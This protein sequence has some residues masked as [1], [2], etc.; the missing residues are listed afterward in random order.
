[1]KFYYCDEFVL[2]LPDRH[3]FPMRKYAM[4][5]ERILAEGVIPA[6]RLEVPPAATDD[7]MK[8]AHDAEYVERVCSGTLTPEQVRRLGFPWSPELVER[9][10]RSVGGTIAAARSALMYGAGMNLAGGTHHAF[11]DRGEGFCVFNDSV[12]AART[13]QQREEIQKV[14]ILDCDV[15]QGN[16]TAKIVEADPTIFS[17]SIH[18]ARNYPIQ[19]EVSD[20]DIAL[21]DEADDALYLEALEEGMEEALAASEPDLVCYL[22]GADPYHKDRFG[23]LGL[24]REGLARRDRMVLERLAQANI[25][26]SIS[27]AGGYAPE[28][29][30]IVALHYQT[31]CIAWELFGTSL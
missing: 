25:P 3:R 10:R 16:G 24:S 23:R 12:V 26:V 27:M 7:E 4:L 1:M 28:I 6:N 13:L 30:D 9:S 29:E 14:L 22:A 8:L 2:P 5:R 19:K 18:G 11:R 15:H 17:F 21:P 31:A 20:L